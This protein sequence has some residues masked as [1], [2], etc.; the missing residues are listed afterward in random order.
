MFKIKSVT[1][2]LAIDLRCRKYKECHENG[3][4][5]VEK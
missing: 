2:T 1:N 4:D 5:Q 3:E